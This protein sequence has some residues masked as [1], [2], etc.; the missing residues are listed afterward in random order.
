EG[1][2]VGGQK[3]SPRDEG[4]DDSLF[5]ATMGI[6]GERGS[7]L[8]SYE[9]YTRDIILASDRPGLTGPL[10]LTTEEGIAE[11]AALGLISPT[12]FPGRYRRLDPVTGGL[13]P[14]GDARRAWEAGPGC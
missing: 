3:S 5:Y 13:F 11:A 9:N 14:V 10:D 4:G 7:M 1:L 2:V 12:G 6:S 8:F